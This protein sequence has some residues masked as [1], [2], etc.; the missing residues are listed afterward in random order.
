MYYFSCSDKHD[1]YYESNN[2]EASAHLTQRT[3]AQGYNSSVS[4]ATGML[5]GAL[6]GAIAGVAAT[7]LYAMVFPRAA[8]KLKRLTPPGCP[9]PFANYSQVCEIVSPSRLVYVSGQPGHDANGKL[10][11][12]TTAQAEQCFAN[13][14]AHLEG[15]GMSK[16]D[17][18]KINVYLSSADYLEGYRV[19]RDNALGDIQPASTLVIVAALAGPGMRVEIEAVAA[20]GGGMAAA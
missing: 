8:T 1:K 15:I 20:T 16:E 13:I 17:L 7:R 14:S 11:A 2:F 9:K 4:M 5:T 3:R 18:V 19:A 6:A 10:A 12:D